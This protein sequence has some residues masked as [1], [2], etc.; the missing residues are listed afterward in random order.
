MKDQTLPSTSRDNWRLPL[1]HSTRG[2]VL[3]AIRFAAV[4]ALIIAAASTPG[5]FTTVSLFS[6]LNTTSFIGCIAIGMTFITLS[7]NIMSFAL[8]VTLSTSGI[9]FVAALPLGLIPAM[10]AALTFGAAL[11]AVQGAVIGYF[12]ANPI[13]VSMAALAL[14][15][16]CATLITQGRGVYPAGDEAALLKG[17]VLGVPIPVAALIVTVVVA[18]IVLSFTQFGRQLY[19]VGSNWRAA[20]AAG[21]EPA[22]VVLGAY[23]AAGLCAAVAG[24]L[25]AAR[26]SSGDMEL[27]IGYDYSAI[28]AVL[29]GGTAISGGEGSA[30]RSLTG[31]FIIAVCQVLL[32]LNG[33]SSQIQYLA[34]GV[35]VLLVIMLQTLADGG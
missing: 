32:L 11:T 22:R 13:I 34:I 7:G 26:Y 3:V 35:I 17:R 19:M 1:P 31:A 30:I 33:F 14:I 28:S 2:R 29:V 4:L 9:V 27:G 25:M 18:Q 24:I 12:R 6:L 15:T 10:I 23:I 21:L 5:F 16:G 20:L 8:G